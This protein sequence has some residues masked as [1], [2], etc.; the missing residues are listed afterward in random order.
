[1]AYPRR[2]TSM[3]LAGVSLTPMVTPPGVSS[4]TRFGVIA[5]TQGPAE[6]DTWQ[7]FVRLYEVQRARYGG[8]IGIRL[9]SPAKLPLPGEPGMV[10]RLLTWAIAEHPEE[11]ITISHRERDDARLRRFLDVVAS[12]GL[13]VSIIY[14]H[15]A[16]AEWHNPRASPPTYLATYRAYRDVIDRH[17]AQPRVTLE[18]NLM[19]YW[20]RYNNRRADWH[21]YV[22]LN[23][24]ADF[25]SWDTYTFPGVAPSQTHY[26]TPDD[27]F[28]YA[29]DAWQEYGLQW[30]I[31]EIGSAVQS[32][33]WDQNGSRFVAWVREI[34]A[35]AANPASIDDSYEG[36]PA[37]RF[38]KWWC[39]LDG[40]DHELGLDQASAA[41]DAYRP[42]VKAS[43]L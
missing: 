20:Q 1:M 14:F 37:A 10:G 21:E 4:P 9:F 23:D 12:E 33:S 27:F 2:L 8:P 11:L 40:D 16:Q 32:H 30:A 29:R 6:P 22:E 19:W 35:A 17:P 13:R 42:L 41:V 15:E 24:P 5:A 3:L 39:A 25:L 43:P 31:G 34:T 36:M 26:S 38:V 28:K 18:K 7:N